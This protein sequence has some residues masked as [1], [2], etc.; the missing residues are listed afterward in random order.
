MQETQSKGQS[1]AFFAANAHH[2]NGQAE[3]RIRDLQ[4]NAR[5]M[6]LH[7]KQ[8]WPEAVTANLWPFA[9]RHAND[10]FNASSSIAKGS[11]GVSLIE[12]FS[13]VQIAP[14][15]KPAHTF[16]S[17]VCALDAKFQEN[18][19]VPK[20]REEAR[21][22]AHLG[23]PPRHSR[24]VAHVLSLATGHVSPQFHCMCDD[25]FDTLRASAGN[26]RP[27]SKWLE[28]TSFADKELQQ[29]AHQELEFVKASEGNQLDGERPI[30]LPFNAGPD[31]SKCVT[32]GDVIPETTPFQPNKDNKTRPVAEETSWQQN[33]VHRSV[34]DA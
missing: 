14:R 6:L 3:K 15:L 16:A 8:R 5:T 33:Q 31:A 2:Q 13:Q 28:K 25:M 24:K 18:K 12:K 30:D 1:I 26:P 23:L 20:W 22:G 29:Q 27:H 7:A 34:S 10:V 17:P 4:E 21:V 11:K 9:L 19:P 32:V